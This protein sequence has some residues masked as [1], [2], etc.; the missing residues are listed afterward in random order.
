[1]V[2]TS[3]AVPEEVEVVLAWHAA[4]NAG[5]ADRLVALSTADVEVGGP[6]GAGQGADLLR[7]WVERARIQLEPV[8][9]QAQGARVV[10]EQRASWQTSDG[11]LSEPQVVASVFG[12]QAGKVSS[13]IRH[14]DF[15]AVLEA[16]RAG[17]SRG[18]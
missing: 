16:A 14:A 3:D 6:R 5:D 12:V 4:L 11:Q 13:V 7:E 15:E 10:V 17:W 8:R 1:V 18:V 9:W 2:V